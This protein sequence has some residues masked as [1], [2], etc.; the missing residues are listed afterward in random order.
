MRF[1]D[2][3]LALL[4]LKRLDQCRLLPADV[5]ARPKVHV[6]IEVVARAARLL[7]AMFSCFINA[8]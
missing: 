3:D 2:S 5:R 8:F 1:S 7:S 6:Q 4:A